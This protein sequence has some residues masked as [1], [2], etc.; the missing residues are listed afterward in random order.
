MGSNDYL[1][2]S[3]DK[4]VAKRTLETYRDNGRLTR[5]DYESRKL[6]LAVAKDLGDLEKIFEDLGEMPDISRP[7][8][9]FLRPRGRRVERLDIVCMVVF[10]AF[11]GFAHFI[12]HAQWTVLLLCAIIFVPMIPRAI[13]ELNR[14]EELHYYE[15]GTKKK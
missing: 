13:V 10:I 9:V 12:L 8:Q 4:S 11:V 15:S 2:N 3:D 14:E 1:L 5:E 6:L 7:K